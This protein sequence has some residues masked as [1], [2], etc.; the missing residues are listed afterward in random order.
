MSEV[1]IQVIDSGIGISD[2][3]IPNALSIFGQIDN[4]LSRKYEGTGLGPT[5]NQEA[6]RTNA[7]Q[8]LSQ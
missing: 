1:Y 7:W 6:G 5:F 3:G 2:K 8:A 4:K